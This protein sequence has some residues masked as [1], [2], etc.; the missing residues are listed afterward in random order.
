MVGHDKRTE[1]YFEKYTPEYSLNRY[2]EVVEFLRADTHAGSSLLDVG[3]GSGNVLKLLVENTPVNEV[4]GIDVSRTY[5]DKCAA[6]VPGCKTYLASILDKDLQA[7]VGR[8]FRYVLV[9]AVLHHL[10]GRSRS[11]SLAYAREGLR[12]AWSLVEPGGALILVE[13]TFRPRWLMNL[14]F[15]VKRLVSKF[16]SRRVSLLGRLNNLGEPV[17]S[18]FSHTELLR[19]AEKLPGADIV[20]DLKKMKSLPV[21]WRMAGVTERAIS[22]LI[23]RKRA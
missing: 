11:E 17:V 7:I 5:L 1:R 22:V 16:T 21:I 10:I 20:I 2:K 13:P 18:Y 23:V 8:Q 9:G 14:L 4:A 15:Y 12:G 19:E 3:C 6:L